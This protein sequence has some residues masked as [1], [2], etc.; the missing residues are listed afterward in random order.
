MLSKLSNINRR[1]FLKLTGIVVLATSV[2]GALGGCSGGGG[3]STPAPPSPEEEGIAQIILDSINA[4]R[5]EV[6]LD[7]TVQEV[8][9]ISQLSAQRALEMMNGK[10][11]DELSPVPQEFKDGGKGYKYGG[12]ENWTVTGLPRDHFTKNQLTEYFR[13]N[14]QT[15][16]NTPGKTTIRE[17]VYVGISVQEQGDYVWYDIIF[18]HE[19]M[20]KGAALQQAD[21]AQK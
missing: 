16:L 8:D 15:E 3:S 10:K 19:G 4:A 7:G 13:N 11:H 1:K 20:T 2:A 12:R 14:F 9:K 18:A 17:D 6:G 21:R 5:K